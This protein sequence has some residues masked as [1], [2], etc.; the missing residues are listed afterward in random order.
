M[1]RRL[2]NR[3]LYGRHPQENKPRGFYLYGLAAVLLF[4]FPAI[5]WIQSAVQ[6][7]PTYVKRNRFMRCPPVTPVTHSSLREQPAHFLLKTVWLVGKIKVIKKRCIPT[8]CPKMRQGKLTPSK[9]CATCQSR[10]G[11]ETI[12]P[13][14]NRFQKAPIVLDGLPQQKSLICRGNGCQMKCNVFQ[15]GQRYA[16]AG[17]VRGHWH[18]KPSAKKA[19]FTLRSFWVSHFCKIKGSYRLP[20]QYTKP[21]KPKM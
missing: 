14:L 20:I 3:W 13:Q 9:C 6:T 4:L 16:V 11:L 15:I 1:L 18:K 8:P 10:L 17:R 7:E 21:K 5:L 12:H 2:L 19:L